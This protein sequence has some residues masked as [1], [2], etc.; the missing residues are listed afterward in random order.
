[1]FG[2]QLAQRLW[3]LYNFHS[4][5]ECEAINASLGRT[6]ANR[7][8]PHQ[9]AP[10]HQ[11]TVVV[12]HRFWATTGHSVFS[13]RDF[14]AREEATSDSPL[15]IWC[16]CIRLTVVEFWVGCRSLPWHHLSL[17]FHYLVSHSFL[18]AKYF[19]AVRVP[20]V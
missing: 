15:A 5:V 8:P 19:L 4:V 14:R 2:K 7:G 1:M 11:P 17:S 20:S 3:P 10:P 6:P 13:F 12:I 9:F 16:V 18:A